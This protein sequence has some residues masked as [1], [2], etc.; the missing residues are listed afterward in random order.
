MCYNLKCTNKRPTLN[1]L[2]TIILIEHFEN[3][4]FDLLCLLTL[5]RQSVNTISQYLTFHLALFCS[6][7]S[8]HDS[9]FTFHLQSLMMSDSTGSINQWLEVMHQLQLENENIREYLQ[10]LQATNGTGERRNQVPCYIK[11][12]PICRT[13]SLVNPRSNSSSPHF[14]Y[15]T[16]C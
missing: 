16:Q 7:L 14:N 3:R 10:K 8:V 15:R 2:T 4:T 9:F 12:S 11:E 13:W 6:T 1:P 5:S